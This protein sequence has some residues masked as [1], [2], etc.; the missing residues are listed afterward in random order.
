MLRGIPKVKPIDPSE[1]EASKEVW[2][3]HTNSATSKEGC[4][5]GLILT[6]PSGDEITYALRFDFHISN[7][8]VEYCW[9][10]HDT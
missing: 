9:P 1:P 8:E 2:E 4:K 5:A 3:L 6:N 7:N 10:S